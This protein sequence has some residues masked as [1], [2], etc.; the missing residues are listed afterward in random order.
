MLITTIPSTSATYTIFGWL[1]LTL[2]C[3]ILGCIL[4]S[5]L[6]EHETACDSFLKYVPAQR[7]AQ[8]RYQK[9]FVKLTKTLKGHLN[10]E[11][12]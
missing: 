8:N 6:L 5:L 1:L 4:F 9:T 10:K 11:S 7:W 3:S 12:L 2:S